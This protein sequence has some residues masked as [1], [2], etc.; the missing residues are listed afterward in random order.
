M[1]ETTKTN[2]FTQKLNLFFNNKT[3]NKLIT[4]NLSSLPTNS[5]TCFSHEPNKLKTKTTHELRRNH[6]SSI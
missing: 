5:I 3:L 4:S 2:I 1:Y 6:Q